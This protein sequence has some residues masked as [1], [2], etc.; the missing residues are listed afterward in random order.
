MFGNHNAY[1]TGPATNDVLVDADDNYIA[2]YKEMPKG[3]VEELVITGTAARAPL[4]YG[5]MQIA[6]QGPD[7]RERWK[8]Q[9]PEYAWDS[10]DSEKWGWVSGR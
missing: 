5:S 9:D 1:L 7:G 2:L 6:A 10:G 3:V 8:Y 4:M